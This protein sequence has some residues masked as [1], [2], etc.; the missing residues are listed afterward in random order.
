MFSR[1]FSTL[2][3]IKQRDVSVPYG[4]VV[5]ETLSSV[6]KVFAGIKHF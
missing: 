3:E 1:Y 4:A 2:S 6:A 5:I